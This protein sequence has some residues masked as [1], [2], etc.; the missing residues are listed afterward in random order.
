MAPAL[1]EA[2]DPQTFHVAAHHHHHHSSGR[3][4]QPPPSRTTSPPAAHLPLQYGGLKEP[5]DCTDAH[6][7]AALA[8]GPRRPPHLLPP[9]SPTGAGGLA[10][11]QE[12]CDP[13]PR[14]HPAHT[15]MD[16]QPG[17]PPLTEADSNPQESEVTTMGQD[18]APAPTHD[19]TIMA[20]HKSPRPPTQDGDILALIGRDFANVNEIIDT[21][22][23]LADETPEALTAALTIPGEAPP[24]VSAP[25]LP[26]EERARVLV[27]EL[28]R[29]QWLLERRQAR[30]QRRLRRVTA[31]GLSATV[32][33]QLRDLLGHAQVCLA[34]QRE[35]AA[36]AAAGVPATTST[37]SNV[38]PAGSSV[39]PSG[40]DR[41][42]SIHAPGGGC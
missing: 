2:S 26:R 14:P 25:P 15:T 22:T 11:E 24:Q 28:G 36:A 3:P 19:T 30:L 1:T 42:H 27:E 41:A 10:C 18:T 16:P 6:L 5:H 40:D 31:R 21:L 12:G 9:P 32:S 7:A 29:R 4:G 34:L 38:P 8:N 13:L 35:E 37:T 20:P 39:D 23:R 33:G 17:Q